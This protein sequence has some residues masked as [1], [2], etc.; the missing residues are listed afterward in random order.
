MGISATCTLNADLYPLYLDDARM[1]HYEQ[2]PYLK[3]LLDDGILNDAKFSEQKSTI[4][5][6][7]RSS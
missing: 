3:T 5:D 4:L 2:L 1:K 6:A 7:L